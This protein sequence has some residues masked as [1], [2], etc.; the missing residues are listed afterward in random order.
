MYVLFNKVK[1]NHDPKRKE[2][3]QSWREERG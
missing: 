2:D 3:Y 1:T